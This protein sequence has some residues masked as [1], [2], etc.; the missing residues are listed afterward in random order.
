MQK[1]MG[2]PPTGVLTLEQFGRM[3]KA[4]RDMD[5]FIGVQPHKTVFMGADGSWASA[6]G[7]FV[8]LPNKINHVEIFCLR[9][10]GTCERSEATFDLDREFLWLNVGDEYQIETWTTSRVTAISEAPCFRVI[11]SI[12]VKGKEVT[13]LA[14]PHPELSSCSGFNSLD[15]PDTWKLVDGHPVAERLWR[16]RRNQA[17]A[18]IYPPSQRLIPI[19]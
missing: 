9:A 12:D 4:A 18:L 10:R 8:G 5:A 14:V 6:A 3:A 7:S 15:G 16:D 17:R 11:M 2:V 19:Q 1:Q 13:F